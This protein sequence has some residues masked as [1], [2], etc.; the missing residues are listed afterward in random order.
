M[1]SNN[2]NSANV[3]NEIKRLK[4]EIEKHSWLIGDELSNE[5]LNSLEQRESEFIEQA[6]WL[7]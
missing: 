3:L 2:M 6:M 4:L 1:N 5:I 7:S